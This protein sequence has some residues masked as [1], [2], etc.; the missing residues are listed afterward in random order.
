MRQVQGRYDGTS[1]INDLVQIDR[2]GV[3]FRTVRVSVL[4]DPY[5][6]V[7]FG[8][9]HLVDSEKWSSSLIYFLFFAN[10]FFFVLRVDRKTFPPLRQHD[11]FVQV[12]IGLHGHV[13]LHAVD[14]TSPT[15]VG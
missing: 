2:V 6:L 4:M 15:L 8:F 7:E 10:V 9:R 13:F 5:G 3:V 11:M 14:R 12:A 1:D